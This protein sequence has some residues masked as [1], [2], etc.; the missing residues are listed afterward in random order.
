MTELSF[1][2]QKLINVGVNLLYHKNIYSLKDLCWA[3]RSHRRTVPLKNLSVA[4]KVF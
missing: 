2:F 3:V 1:L 4:Q